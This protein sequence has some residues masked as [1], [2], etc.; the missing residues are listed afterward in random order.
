M[1]N[2]PGRTNRRWDVIIPINGTVREV[3]IG[4]Y[5]VARFYVQPEREAD[6]SVGEF[7]CALCLNYEWFCEGH[8]PHAGNPVA[9]AP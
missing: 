2:T 4:P 3:A 8:G 1:A 7:Q 5:T 9:L 6:H